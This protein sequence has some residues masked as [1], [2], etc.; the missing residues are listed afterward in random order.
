MAGGV[1]EL[2]RLSIQFC[3]SSKTALKIKFSF[4]KMKDEEKGGEGGEEEK[5]S[6]PQLSGKNENIM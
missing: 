6:Y 4:L 5:E 2:S 3:C 1:W